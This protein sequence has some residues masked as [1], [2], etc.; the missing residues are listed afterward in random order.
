MSMRIAGS[1]RR[2]W[3]AFQLLFVAYTRTG[4]LPALSAPLV[5]L[6]AVW[7]MCYAAGG[8]HTAFPHLFYVPIVLAAV[9]FGWV[10]G[11]ASGLVAGLLA[12]PALPADV[13]AGTAQPLTGWV[14]RTGIFLAIGL[15]IGWLMRGR[16]ESI[17]AAFQDTAV[18][19]RLVHGVHRGEFEVFYQPIHCLQTRRIVGFEALARWN[20]PRRGQV[21]PAEFIPA[22]ERTGAIAVLD[23]FVLAQAAAQTQRWSSHMS[24]VSV[25]VNVSATRFTQ[26]DLATNVRSVLAETGLAPGSLQLEITES[27]VIDD[28][29]AAS[30]QVAELRALGARIAIDDFGTGQAALG[31]LEQLSVDTVKIDR[32]LVAQVAVSAR[33]ARLVAGLIDLFRAL[34]LDVVVEGI[35]TAEQYAHLESAGAH[36]AQGFYLGRPMSARD[37][38]AALRQS[39]HLS[40]ASTLPPAPADQSHCGHAAPTSHMEPKFSRVS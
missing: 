32:S 2:G 16:S 17:R 37:A 31:Y 4:P 22:A 28:V 35:E 36:L 6:P 26:G 14:L 19:G 18:S 33:T 5:C 38:E 3:F 9:R 40:P 29:P 10:G 7:A 34:H 24:A 21:G 13:A 20:H 12:G 39:L 11:A 15:L 25:S 27:A 1:L 30:R 23:R 8:S